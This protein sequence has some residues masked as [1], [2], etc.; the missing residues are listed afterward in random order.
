MCNSFYAQHRVDMWHTHIERENRVDLSQHRRV[1]S[2]NIYTIVHDMN[3]IFNFMKMNYVH[4]LFLVKV[5]N[6]FMKMSNYW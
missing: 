1:Q 2:F 6:N 3:Y 4:T 5:K